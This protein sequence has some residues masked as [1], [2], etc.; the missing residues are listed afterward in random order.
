MLE[1]LGFGATGCFGLGGGGCFGLGGG[2]EVARAC[3]CNFGKV[4]VGDVV[5]L[6]DGAEGR[7][8]VGEV[9]LFLHWSGSGGRAIMSMWEFAPATIPC[10]HTWRM[11]ATC[12]GM[13]LRD[14]S[15]I[16]ETFVYS[17]DS[18]SSDAAIVIVPPKWR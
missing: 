6:R 2:L 9:V 10:G 18:P 12:R 8:E 14:T 4:M 13:S 3:R 16:E 11:H 15:A 7:I 5:G 17:R 1:E